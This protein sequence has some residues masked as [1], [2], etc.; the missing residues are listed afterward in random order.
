MNIIIWAMATI[1]FVEACVYCITWFIM[2]L[3][4]WY[5]VTWTDKHK[6]PFFFG[7]WVKKGEPS[8]YE[9]PTLYRAV[10]WELGWDK[11]EEINYDGKE[12]S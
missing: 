6:F 1:L 3:R 10:R 7:Y 12:G 9:Q 4:G 5:K 11:N 2:G 8:R